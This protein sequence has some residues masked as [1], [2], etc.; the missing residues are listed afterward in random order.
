MPASLNS[1]QILVIVA[2]PA[3]AKFPFGSEK[4]MLLKGTVAPD[5]GFYF[6]V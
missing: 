1:V 2:G 6:R 3:D 5:I 4:P